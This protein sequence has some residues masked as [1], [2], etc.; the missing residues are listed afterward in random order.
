MTA[1]R[2]RARAGTAAGG[3]RRQRSSA[4]LLWQAVTE[5]VGVKRQGGKEGNFKSHI[6]TQSGGRRDWTGANRRGPPCLQGRALEK[7][8]MRKDLQGAG[9]LDQEAPATLAFSSFQV[10][11][12]PAPLP[13]LDIPGRLRSCPVLQRQRPSIFQDLA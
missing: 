6:I 13:A 9:A 2:A 7:V 3:A 8:A 4:G 12:P 11:L 5:A 10:S 1:L